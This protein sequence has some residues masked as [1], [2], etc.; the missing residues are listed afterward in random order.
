MQKFG[1]T[2]KNQLMAKRLVKEKI[3]KI[4]DIPAEDMMLYEELYAYHNN[5][6]IP[7]M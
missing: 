5:T 4:S 7:T 2:S 3:S 1:I 6:Y